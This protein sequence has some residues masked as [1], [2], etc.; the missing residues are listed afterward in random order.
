MT[1]PFPSHLSDE[2]SGLKCCTNRLGAAR[3]IRHVEAL[4]RRGYSVRQQWAFPSSAIL[5][6]CVDDKIHFLK[7]PLSSRSQCPTVVSRC[8][9]VHW[10][11]WPKSSPTPPLLCFMDLPT[12][13]RNTIDNF[14]CGLPLDSKLLKMRTFCLSTLALGQLEWK[15]WRTLFYL[16]GNSYGRCRV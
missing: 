1:L 4:I 16:V 14:G 2:Q 6:N 13:R 3:A 10:S 12:R 11:R 15:H 8:S 5:H 9:R 7:P